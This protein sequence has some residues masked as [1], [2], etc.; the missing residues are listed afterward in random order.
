MNGSSPRKTSWG[1]FLRARSLTEP[2]RR[3]LAHEVALADLDAETAEDVVRGRR[4]EIETRHREV[5]EVV[6]RAEI[7]RLAAGG[8][9]HLLVL[10]AVELVRLQTLQ[11]VDCLIDPRLHLGV[12]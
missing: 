1:W 12:A 2:L 6:L 8:D 5:I 4:M 7:A 3:H 10:S 9:R 11:E